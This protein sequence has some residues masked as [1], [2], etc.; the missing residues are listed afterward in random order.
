MLLFFYSD[1]Q[2]NLSSSLDLES[3]AF[4]NAV[5]IMGGRND[6]DAH[7]IL[8]QDVYFLV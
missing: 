3:V 5:F 4:N 2:C 6:P 7:G 1:V 8:T